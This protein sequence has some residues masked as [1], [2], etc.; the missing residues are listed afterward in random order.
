MP[1]NKE[2]LHGANG[3]RAINVAAAAGALA[4]G[5]A[6]VGAHRGDRVRLAGE[7]IPLFEAPLGG[8][9]QVAATVRADGARLLALNVALQP[10][11]VDGLNEEFL[12]VEGHEIRLRALGETMLITHES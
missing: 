1:L 11:G 2:A 8:E 6:D 7:E 5:G 12:G 10:R 3:E 4:R 9:V